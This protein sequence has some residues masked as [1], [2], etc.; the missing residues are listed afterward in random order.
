MRRRPSN[1]SNPPA[2]RSASRDRP[3]LSTPRANADRDAT[4]RHRLLEAAGEVFGERGFDRATGKEICRRAGVN[5]AGVNYHFGG[6]EGLY[7][8]V[9]REAHGR[10]LTLAA[11]S[12]AIFDKTDAKAKLRAIIELLVSAI[13]GPAATS[14]VLRVIGREVV[15]PSPALR[16]LRAKELFPRA[17]IL[18]G[19]VAELMDLNPNH[20]A[21]ER[22]CISVIG[23]CLMLV[24]FDRRMLRRMFPALN[25]G[26]ETAS[27]LIEQLVAFSLAGLETVRNSTHGR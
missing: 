6:M 9:V 19:V 2:R 7:V 16:S 1:Y 15:A 18:K 8:A 21:V 24:V 26:P 14:W 25:P 13:T 22:G 5:A 27:A 12:A 3:L 17:K 23:P 11:I 10:L 20:P 4:T